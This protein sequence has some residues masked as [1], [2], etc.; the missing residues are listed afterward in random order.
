M[1]E[2]EGLEVI[3]AAAHH[4][5]KGCQAGAEEVAGGQM[6]HPAWGPRRVAQAG[7]CGWRPHG[8]HTDSTC[9]RVLSDVTLSS[10]RKDRVLFPLVSHSS[11]FVGPK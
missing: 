5:Q 11:L 3:L 6:L 10:G 1:S 2:S 8:H 9:F 4:L 7:G